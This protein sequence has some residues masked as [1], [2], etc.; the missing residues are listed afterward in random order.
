MGVPNLLK[1]MSEHY[2]LI[3]SPV[4]PLSTPDIGVAPMTK[5]RPQR[6]GWYLSAFEAV[7]VEET[8]SEI[9]KG[10][11]DLYKDCVMPGTN[12]MRKL[13]KWVKYYAQMRMSTDKAWEGLK[14]IISGS[15]VPGEGEHK[16]ISFIRNKR[17]EKGYDP[18]TSHC[19]FGRDADLIMLALL[20]HERNIVILR[21]INGSSNNNPQLGLNHRMKLQFL[22]INILREYLGMWF[23]EFMHDD[24]VDSDNSMNR[25]FGREREE[26]GRNALDETKN[27]ARTNIKTSEKAQNVPSSQKEVTHA[28]EFSSSTSSSSST[29]TTSSSSNSSSKHLLS[30]H[31]DFERV[32]DDFVLLCFLLGNDFIPRIVSL[33]VCKRAIPKILT[34]YK[35]V[36]PT[37]HSFLTERG[38]VTDWGAFEAICQKLAKEESKTVSDLMFPRMRGNGTRNPSSLQFPSSSDSLSFHSLTE[39]TQFADL[40][41]REMYYKMKLHF[42]LPLPDLREAAEIKRS[43]DDNETANGKDK[44]SSSFSS[45]CSSSCDASMDSL[46]PFELS[47]PLRPF[48]QLL[49]VLHPIYSHILPQPLRS[50]LNSSSSPLSKYIDSTLYVDNGFTPDR[51]LKRNK[52]ALVKYTMDDKIWKDEEEEEN[53]KERSCVENMQQ[54]KNG[55]SASKTNASSALLSSSSTSSFSSS[56]SSSSSFLPFKPLP[57]DDIIDREKIVSLHIGS[58]ALLPLIDPA[59]VIKAAEELYPK[60]SKEEMKRNQIKW[61][62][63]LMGPKHPERKT[64]MERIREEAME[65]RKEA[66]EKWRKEEDKRVKEKGGKEE[67]K[68]NDDEE[69][70]LDIRNKLNEEL[71]SIENEEEAKIEAAYPSRLL[72][73]PLYPDSPASATLT[74]PSLKQCRVVVFRAEPHSDLPLEETDEY[75][76]KTYSTSGSIESWRENFIPFE[77]K[78]LPGSYLRSGFS[79]L[80]VLR[81]PSISFFFSHSLPLPSSAAN[82]IPMTVPSVSCLTNSPYL[83]GQKEENPKKEKANRSG[84]K[85]K[86]EILREIDCFSKSL[87]N[88]AAFNQNKKMNSFSND[89]DCTSPI[90]CV[91]NLLFTKMDNENVQEESTKKT[92]EQHESIEKRE[93]LEEQKINNLGE[94]QKL[95]Q[96]LQDGKDVNRRRE[97]K[98]EN[99]GAMKMNGKMFDK[100]S[101]IEENTDMDTDSSKKSDEDDEK[102]EKEKLK[103]EMTKMLSHSSSLTKLDLRTFLPRSFASLSCSSRLQMVSDVLRLLVGCVCYVSYPHLIPARVYRIDAPGI[104]FVL[105]PMASEREEEEELKMRR[106]ERKMDEFKSKMKEERLSELSGFGSCEDIDEQTMEEY[107]EWKKAREEEAIFC[108]IMKAMWKNETL[109]HKHNKSQEDADDD[110]FDEEIDDNEVKL[111]DDSKDSMD[112]NETLN[113]VQ[114]KETCKE[115]SQHLCVPPSP[116]QNTQRL[117]NFSGMRNQ[118]SQSHS[119]SDHSQSQCCFPKNQKDS[120]SSSTSSSSSS[121]FTSP[122]LSPRSITPSSPSSPSSSSSSS[123]SSS[124]SSSSPSP[125]TSFPYSATASAS[126]TQA[127]FESQSYDNKS[128]NRGTPRAKRSKSTCLSASFI[129]SILQIH[130]VLSL[131]C[132]SLFA[133]LIARS[134]PLQPLSDG[135]FRSRFLFVKN[136]FEKQ[137]IDVGKTSSILCYVHPLCS[138]KKGWRKRRRAMKEDEMKRVEE[139]EKE[140]NDELQKQNKYQSWGIYTNPN[141]TVEEDEDYDDDDDDNDFKYEKKKFM[142]NYAEAEKLVQR[143]R[144]DGEEVSKADLERAQRRLEKGLYGFYSTRSATDGKIGICDVW[145]PQKGNGKEKFNSESMLND[146]YDYDEEVVSAEY[147]VGDAMCVPIQLISAIPSFAETV[148]A[149]S[150][151]LAELKQQ[152]VAFQSFPT[153]TPSLSPS[154][155]I[156]VCGSN[157]SV[158]SV[159]RRDDSGELVPVSISSIPHPLALLTASGS[160]LSVCNA[161]DKELMV[162]NRDN[163]KANADDKNKDVIIKVEF[164]AFEEQISG[165]EAS[166]FSNIPFTLLHSE[167]LSQRSAESGTKLTILPPK[168]SLYPNLLSSYLPS[169]FLWFDV[170]EVSKLLHVSHLTILILTMPNF[171]LTLTKRIR[172]R[173]RNSGKREKRGQ[174]IIDAYRVYKGCFHADRLNGVVE[175]KIEDYSGSESAIKI[176]CKEQR[177]RRNSNANNQRDLPEDKKTDVEKVF[178]VSEVTLSFPFIDLVKNIHSP[179]YARFNPMKG[180]AEYSSLAMQML[181]EYKKEFPNVFNLCEVFTSIPNHKM[182]CDASSLFG[183]VDEEK[184]MKRFKSWK[185]E[186]MELMFK[187]SGTKAG[188]CTSMKLTKMGMNVMD[189]YEKESG[190]LKNTFTCD[191]NERGLPSSSTDVL[192]KN[193]KAKGA[194]IQVTCS[195]HP[196]CLVSAIRSITYDGSDTAGGQLRIGDRVV[197]VAATGLVPF[198]TLGRVVASA[199]PTPSHYDICPMHAKVLQ[200]P[201]VGSDAVDC[202]RCSTRGYKHSSIPCDHPFL[203]EPLLENSCDSLSSSVRTTQKLAYRQSNNVC[204]VTVCWERPF[205]CCHF[206]NGE[207]EKSIGCDETSKKEEENIEKEKKEKLFCVYDVAADDVYR[208]ASF[209]SP[210]R[211]IQ[212][213]L[214]P[215]QKLC[216]SL[217]RREVQSFKEITSKA[218]NSVEEGECIS[219]QFLSLTPFKNEEKSHFINSLADIPLI[220]KKAVGM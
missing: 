185:N 76:L 216:T 64:E 123:P 56:S 164:D 104:S 80:Y 94:Q 155:V 119:P 190:W 73:P 166:L 203:I 16:I 146:I 168:Y 2:P 163:M 115:E 36:L 45:S 11:H 141:D 200:T 8:H 136:K 149:T 132:P 120:S 33:E 60:V 113:E 135:C 70:K 24:K 184:E 14:V 29:A 68:E 30:F 109:R 131:N 63:V 197:S 212:D 214:F 114:T 129:K 23:K 61:N 147:N 28:S 50:L 72:E 187:Q 144:A 177:I 83:T 78:L 204:S 41:W 205:L 96:Q 165:K 137:G 174:L 171:S 169:S 196:K 159:S 188:K 162:E 26:K 210:F 118:N 156:C 125:S 75:D 126:R 10:K 40:T 81:K 192:S 21:E 105:D 152:L 206:E 215:E 87:L 95:H 43:I 6:R 128:F 193:E 35:E 175:K 220:M 19:I 160:V 82:R 139:E 17:R 182:E 181:Q 154:D 13:K 202:S 85:E 189:R 38:W 47:Q 195:I 84:E 103:E 145:N 158:L 211:K 207:D 130:Y 51:F 65:K 100:S 62:L 148:N 74:F 194:R 49:S 140:M 107:K 99:D 89:S 102:E 116:H 5:V 217:V 110:D 219:S 91:G 54:G 117:E 150:E 97:A 101:K 67:E 111:F 153:E 12:L 44:S 7:M 167:I 27:V 37:M 59:I 209:T 39:P 112:S 142:L 180:C 57:T 170:D 179:P 151:Q 121:S 86:E 143:S 32:L 58:I 178:Y 208:Y 92:K 183:F 34:A 157:L 106:L 18:S 79:S 55:L 201:A 71:V 108:E 218:L 15:D 42:P 134:V 173:K 1:W 122:S 198:G 53:R 138:M 124:P 90:I 20:T 77:S 93:R 88:Q 46:Y 25:R 98:D 52:Q 31:F 172:F 3:F 161:T 186:K 176:W 133:R 9:E 191:E 48:E 213:I 66:I 69:R 4:D 199:Y 22:H 127:Q